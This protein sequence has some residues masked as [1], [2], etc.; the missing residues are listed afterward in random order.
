MAKFAPAVGAE[1]NIVADGLL[2]STK[3]ANANIIRASSSNRKR[4]TGRGGQ[5][6][7]GSSAG[8]TNMDN[9]ISHLDAQYETL[10]NKAEWVTYAANIDGHWNT[11]ANCALE[12]TGKKLFRQY[13]YNRNLIGLAPVTVPL[14]DTEYTD[15]FLH[16]VV[17]A[18]DG[19]P[20]FVQLFGGGGGLAYGDILCVANLGLSLANP[21]G[22]F[23]IA[24]IVSTI[25]ISGPFFEWV[26]K[27]MTLFPT[28]LDGPGESFDICFFKSSG[29]PGQRIPCLFQLN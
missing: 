27:I 12:A 5:A 28:E 11:C 13:N 29:A 2:Y 21:I 24:D 23:T 6:R 3:A 1:T 26:V 9:L 20:A 16:N 19:M 8:F 4:A 25:V 10:S 15:S 22:S 18:P 14:D 7:M 17:W